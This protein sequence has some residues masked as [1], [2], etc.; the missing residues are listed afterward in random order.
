MN[1][2]SAVFAGVAGL[3]GIAVAVPLLTPSSGKAAPAAMVP[4]FPTASSEASPGASSAAR[5]PR[6]LRV[7]PLGASTTAGVGSSD[8]GG[9]RLPLGRLVAA[10]PEYAI[11]FVGSRAQGPMEDNQHEGHPGYTV[12]RIRAGVD[13]WIE[14][15][16][17]DVVLLHIGLNNLNRGGD[18]DQAADEAG[19]LV[20]R[21]F[22]LRPG[23]TVIMQG[24]VPSTPGSKDQDISGAIAEYNRN[25]K[26]IE[27][28][29]QGAG[30][31]FR[32]VKAP[33]LTPADRADATT[34]AELAD[35]LHPNDTGYAKV[36][37]AFF[38]AMERAHS[39]GWFG[40]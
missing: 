17:P 21:I 39:D 33:W 38:E 9:Y 3:A 20:D 7:M 31:H 25:L 5:A 22:T 37:D 8:F 14:A 18:P 10:R 27:T 35:G 12:G 28:R 34:P 26:R 6:T 36:A 23:I 15:A 40:K 13:R 19:E 1:R 4:P 24:L 29:E 30:R 16:N 2:R 11:D 32:F